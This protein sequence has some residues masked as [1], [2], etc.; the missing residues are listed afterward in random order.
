M[1]QIAILLFSILLSFSTLAANTQFCNESLS[2]IPIRQ[3]GRIK[4]L[5]V[6]ASE[7]MKYLT[8]KSKVGENSATVS[9]C[10]LSINGLGIPTKIKLFAKIE[11]VDLQKLLEVEKQKKISYDELEDQTAVLRNE[12]RKAED[13]SSYKKSLGSLLGKIKIHKD[14]KTANNWQVPLVNSKTDVAWLPIGAYLSEEKIKAAR[15]VSETPFLKVLLDSKQ[16]YE[17]TVGN[18]FLIELQYVKLKLPVVA[19][20]LTFLGLICITLFRKFHFALAFAILTVIVQTAILT[21][22]VYISGRAP[23]TNMYE[24]V[25][26][27]GYGSLVL[28]LIIGHFKNEKIYVFVGLAYNVCTLMMLNFAGGMLSSSISPLVPVLRDNFWLSTHVTTIILSYGALALS[29]VLANT[30]LIKKKFSHMS[31]KDE[32][33]YSELIYTC[34]KAG[35]VMLATGIILGGVWADYSWGRFWGWDPKETWSLIVLCLYIAILHGKSTNWIPNNRFFI[36]VAGA[37]MSVM[38]AWFGVNYILASGLHS[39]GF[40][41]GGAIFLGSFFLG[42]LVVLALTY[43]SFKVEEAKPNA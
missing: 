38:M 41:E 22:R 43:S 29:W 31:K 20:C 25:L 42:Q 2:A 26:F 28:A 21:F 24:T 34:L 30:V 40:S 37:F 14:I 33:Y 18:K 7:M 16:Q 12:W 5:L 35:T 3:D 39:Y 36:L 9:Y 27:S 17:K 15:A 4:P 11:H 1:K 19:L 10:L 6:H 13:F 8:G 32:H 23:I